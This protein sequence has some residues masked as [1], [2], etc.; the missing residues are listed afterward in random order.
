[1]L[2]PLDLFDLLALLPLFDHLAL[3]ALFAPLDLHVRALK[4]CLPLGRLVCVC[5]LLVTCRN[6][7][8]V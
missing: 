2:D 4:I 6:F 5:T 1:M 8:T 7:L 3:L